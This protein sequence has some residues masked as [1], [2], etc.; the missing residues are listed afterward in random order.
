[1]KTGKGQIYIIVSAILFGTMPMLTKIAFCNGANPYS[2]AFWRFLWAGIFLAIII[3]WF[4]KGDLLIERKELIQIFV[5]S[6]PYALTPIL[7]YISYKYI[8]SGLAT[9]LHFTYPISVMLIACCFFK[10]KPDKKKTIC[11]VLCIIGISMLYSP[12]Q[13]SGSLGMIMAVVSGIV[14]SIYVILLEKT[15]IKNIPAIITSFWL[16]VFATVEIGMTALL[17]GKL[18]VIYTVEEFIAEICLAF[19]ATVMALVLFQKGAFLCGAIQASLL[20]TFEPLTGVIIG[21]FIFK[22]EITWEIVFGILLILV[23]TICLAIPHKKREKK[24]A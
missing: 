18:D 3:K 15:K 21:I 20:S 6:V 9:S 24:G 2:A 14:Y 5:L 7:L 8:D 16:C 19:F 4:Y 10:M 22:E 1:M 13:E 17:L 11:A 23:S 12:G